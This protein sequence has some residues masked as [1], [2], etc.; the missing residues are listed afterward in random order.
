LENEPGRAEGAG[1]ISEEDNDDEDEEA[2]V[3]GGSG[4]SGISATGPTMREG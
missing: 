4:N 1:S 2:P 3:G